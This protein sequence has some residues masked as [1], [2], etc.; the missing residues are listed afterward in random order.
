MGSSYGSSLTNSYSLLS[1]H[2]VTCKM[3]VTMFHQECQ[4]TPAYSYQPSTDRSTPVGYFSYFVPKYGWFH[5]Y[6]FQPASSVSSQPSSVIKN[7]YG[8]LNTHTHVQPYLDLGSTGLGL[9]RASE[10]FLSRSSYTYNVQSGLRAT[11]RSLYAH[12]DSRLQSLLI[13]N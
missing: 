2:S 12:R 7:T 5:S 9:S 8:G 4:G 3:G 11:D 6:L 10:F 1:F 13:S